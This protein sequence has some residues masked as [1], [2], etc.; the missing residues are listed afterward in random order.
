[1]FITTTRSGDSRVAGGDRL[2]LRYAAFFGT[3]LTRKLLILLK[4]KFLNFCIRS[5][6]SNKSQLSMYFGNYECL[7][8]DSTLLFSATRNFPVSTLAKSYIELL[9]LG[10][11]FLAF[12]Y[13]LKFSYELWFIGG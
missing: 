7:K 5:F 8:D 1:M 10:F 11:I 13:A 9:N 4:L 6:Y 2:S 12:L 3:Y